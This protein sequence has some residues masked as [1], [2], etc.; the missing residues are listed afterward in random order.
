MSV[1]ASTGEDA[2]LLAPHH[3]PPWAAC[4]LIPRPNKYVLG[5]RPEVQLL[6]VDPN[7]QSKE[8]TM[9]AR[10]SIISLTSQIQLT[11]VRI[12]VCEI[13]TGVGWVQLMR[14]MQC[15]VCTLQCNSNITGWLPTTTRIYGFYDE[16]KRRYSIKLWKTFTDCFNCLPIGELGS[17]ALHQELANSLRVLHQV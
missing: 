9:V 11:P 15:P 16:C 10:Y 3:L 14:L 7:M 13:C 12:V 5:M 2:W 1:P 8:V 6:R 4:H 17:L